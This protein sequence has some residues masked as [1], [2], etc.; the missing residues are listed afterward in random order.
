MPA[1]EFFICGASRARSH[2]AISSASGK[3]SLMQVSVIAVVSLSGRDR[4]RARP[5]LALLARFERIPAK[6]HVANDAQVGLRFSLQEV[7]SACPASNLPARSFRTPPLRKQRERVDGQTVVPG[8]RAANRLDDRRQIRAPI[9]AGQLGRDP[10][11]F[12]PV[13]FHGEGGDARGADR[14]MTLLDG[15]LD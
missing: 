11:T 10:E 2:R 15:P 14:G 9:P 7:G 5:L 12:F 3:P 13:F 4:A 8:D 1:S 6:F